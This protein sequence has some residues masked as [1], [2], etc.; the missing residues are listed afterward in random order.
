M[1]ELKVMKFDN[2][3]PAGSGLQ[4]WEEIPQSALVAGKP[5]QSGHNYF[6]DDTGTLTAGV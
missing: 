3:G 6:T 2:A 5:V 4:T 1:S